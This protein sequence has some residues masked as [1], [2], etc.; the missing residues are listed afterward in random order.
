MPTKT[1]DGKWKWGNIKRNSRKELSQTVYGIW[2]GNGSKGSFSKF[3]H[4]GNP[5]GKEHRKSNKN[6]VKES[7]QLNPLSEMLI[8]KFVDKWSRDYG[9]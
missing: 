6:H 7:Y 3:Y 1:K 8:R 2:K 9:N 4:E 5:Y